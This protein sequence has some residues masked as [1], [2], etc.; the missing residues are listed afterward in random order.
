MLIQQAFKYALYKPNAG[1]LRSL[2]RFAGCRRW[3]YNEALKV[4]QENHAAGGKYI[5]YEVMA[6]NLK[7]WRV[8]PATTW[9]KEAPF[10]ILQQALRDLDRAFQNFFDKRA[11]FP[12][13]KKKGMP[14]GFRYPDPAQVKVDEANG[15]MFLPK[16][17]WV[18]YQCSRRIK[19]DVRNITVSKRDGRWFT[20]VQTER[21]VD[22]PIPVATTAIGV[23][24]GIAR[25]AT[26]S[27]GTF[28]AAPKTFDRHEQRLKKY[29]RR[30]SRK[31]KF[32]SNWK[33][34]KAMVTKIYA[35][36]ANC[37]MD[38]T[39]KTST[40][41]SKSHALVAVEDLAVKNMS[42][43]A[44]GTL[45]SPGKNVR[46]KAGLNRSIL[47]QGWGSFVDQL[48]YKLLRNGGFFIAVPP[49]YTSQ[50]CPCCTHVD[51]AN[52]KTQSEFLCVECWY[53]NHADVVGAT[54]TLDKA[55]KILQ[56]Q[57]EEHY[58]GQD[59]AQCAGYASTARIACQVNGVVK[60]S[61]AG[62]HRSD[63]QGQ[64]HAP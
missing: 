32:S 16:L 40:T 59:T 2:S 47:D 24:V 30:M 60:P 31:T 33:K 35:T 64:L 17:G 29:Q 28:F 39:Q 44:A 1:T 48:K 25:F 52:R 9:L 15:R 58:E 61:A 57:Y 36:M 51:K 27:D 4:Q 62:T 53:E 10:H 34:A 21:T 5:R 49:A 26:L 19:G 55:L 13:P 54:N 12:R 23:D 56:E 18:R 7:V 3:V 63:M 14:G 42:A 45:E 6:A 38:Y 22:E 20:S 50:K 8:A 41:I 37:R 11:S 46:A 43:S